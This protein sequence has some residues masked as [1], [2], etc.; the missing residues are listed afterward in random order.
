M[1]EMGFVSEFFPNKNM[2]KI[3]NISFGNSRYIY[4][5]FL[6]I[7]NHTNIKKIVYPD[8]KSYGISSKKGLQKLLTDEKKV[9]NFLNFSHSQSNQASVHH[10]ATAISDYKGGKKGKVKFKNKKDIQSF[11]LPRQKPKNIESDWRIENNHII[12]PQFGTLYKK[13]FKKKA[14]ISDIKIR[15][16]NKIPSNLLIENVSSIVIKR[17]NGTYTISIQF[18]IPEQPK[19]DF[20]NFRILRLMG[21]DAG[22]KDKLVSN[23]GWRPEAKPHLEKKYEEL[24]KN[25]KNLQRKTSI[26]VEK[27]KEKINQNR[28]QPT[29]TEKRRKHVIKS[30]KRDRYAWKIITDVL[31]FKTVKT[32]K[33]SKLENEFI[34]AKNYKYN[35]PIRTLYRK[36]ANIV[37]NDNHHISAF[38]AR[39]SDIVFMETLNIKAFQK[40]WGRSILKLGL[41]DLIK[42]IQYKVENQGGIFYKIDR[43]F[44]ST[45]T[46]HKCKNKSYF[47]LEVREWECGFCGAFHDRDVNAAINILL[48]GFRNLFLEMTKFSLLDWNRT[49]PSNRHETMNFYSLSSLEEDLLLT[50]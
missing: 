3:F 1:K 21:L 47:G 40:L 28:I 29:I 37:D 31:E 2:K 6:H 50:V 35:A 12:I 44:A 38:I 34:F 32:Q 22:M 43:W 36:Q 20:K 42:K 7:T 10:L 19:I 39:S 11:H 41:A 9:S 27:R 33:F 25:R 4:N 48:E 23:T 30:R 24:E 14:V 15:I 13:I 46:C 18:K 26:T 16:K 17:N 45:K 5:N 49:S 8:G